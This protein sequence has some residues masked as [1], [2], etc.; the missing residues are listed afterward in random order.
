MLE[1]IVAP[2]KATLMSHGAIT[3]EHPEEG[4]V[5]LPAILRP[6]A[7]ANVPHYGSLTRAQYGAVGGQVMTASAHEAP[8]GQ[9]AKIVD[10]GAGRAQRALI[11]TIEAS[12]KQVE[13]AKD[14]LGEK[15]S[16]PPLGDDEASRRWRED[17]IGVHKQTV[18]D[19][20]AAVGAATAQMVQ[21]TGGERVRFMV[22]PGDL[23]GRF[24]ANLNV[25][26]IQPLVQPFRPLAAMFQTSPEACEP[27]LR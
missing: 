10:T 19:H 24:Q 13:K 5:A 3:A 11:G 4:S 22:V 16:L 15:P 20:L 8:V 9:Q 17:E 21:L 12:I 25:L 1:D 14:D 18:T 27:W 7:E 6:G 2:A 26:I 23:R